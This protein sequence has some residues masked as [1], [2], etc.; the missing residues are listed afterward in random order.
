MTSFNIFNTIK[1]IELNVFLE[2][3][4]C[5]KWEIIVYKIEH[6]TVNRD[7]LWLG[8]IVEQL[9]CIV[10]SME[11]FKSRGPLLGETVQGLAINLAGNHEK[12]I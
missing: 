6:R 12:S 7:R 5:L 2:D 11:V 4:K 10:T 8:I 3:L 9:V 1:N